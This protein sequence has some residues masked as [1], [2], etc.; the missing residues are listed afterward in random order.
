MNNDK[1]TRR[2]QVFNAIRGVGYI[3]TESE[4]TVVCGELEGPVEPKPEIVR[5]LKLVEFVGE[6]KA[7]ENQMSRGLGTGTRVIGFGEKRVH[8][9]S[10]ILGDYPMVFDA[11]PARL[12]PDHQARHIVARVV[13]MWLGLKAKDPDAS[14][15][16]NIE[17][18]AKDMSGVSL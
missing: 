1:M 17:T 12:S 6:R 13:E 7:V 14:A 4:L 2:A 8:I 15:S 16:V 11:L 9:N 5:V 3:L 10:A 18:I